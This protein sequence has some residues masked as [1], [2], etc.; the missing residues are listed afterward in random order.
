MSIIFQRSP[1]IKQDLP[2][3]VVEISEPPNKPTEPT[4]SYVYLIFPIIMTL[5]TVGLYVY[6]STSGK[7][8]MNSNF[9]FVLDC[10]FLDDGIFL[11]YSFFRLLVP[12]KEI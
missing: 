4:F 9:F 6:M 2:R 11:Y 7:S 10:F 3:Q 5:T 12:E 1:R 8:Y